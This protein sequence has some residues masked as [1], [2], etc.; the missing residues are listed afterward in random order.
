MVGSGAMLSA[1][2][3]GSQGSNVIVV[4]FFL[5]GLLIAATFYGYS[6]TDPAP[7]LLT[8]ALGILGTVLCPPAL[9]SVGFIDIETY[10]HAFDVIG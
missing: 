3:I 8:I 10:T 6:E 9:F 5:L 7:N 4:G 1:A 2:H